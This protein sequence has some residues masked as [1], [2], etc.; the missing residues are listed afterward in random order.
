M[1][2]FRVP[3][4][5]G[6]FYTEITASDAKE[7]CD[8]LPV[9][10]LPNWGCVLFGLARVLTLLVD[11]GACEKSKLAALTATFVLLAICYVE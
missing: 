2:E 7:L 9:S 8:H 10:C 4:Q 11:V 3:L 1:S 5:N 6:R